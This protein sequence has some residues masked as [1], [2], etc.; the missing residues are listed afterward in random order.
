MEV[1]SLRDELN[2]FKVLE[3]AVYG[4]S[5]QN[6]E[7]HKKFV[8]KYSLGFPLLV[9]TGRNISLHYHAIS[10]PKG[11]CKRITILIGKNGDILQVDDKVSVRKHGRDLIDSIKILN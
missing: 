4:I 9:D 10:K 3:T 11:N 1:C 2:D 7:S 8:D 6:Q 5:V